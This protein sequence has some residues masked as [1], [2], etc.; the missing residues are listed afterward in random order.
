MRRQRAPRHHR[1]A[2][3]GRCGKRATAVMDEHLE[4]VAGRALIVTRPPKNRDIKD[5]LAPY[6][7]GGRPR[8]R[9]AG[10][11]QRAKRLSV[12]A[13]ACQ[14]PFGAVVPHVHLHDLAA[15]HHEAID[16]AVAF[17]RRSVGPFAVERAGVVDDGLSLARR[18]IGALH[19]LLHPLVALGVERR[20][21]ARMGELAA[22]REGELEVVRD[23]ARR[24][25]RVRHH[26]GDQEFLDD[27][28]GQSSFIG[29]CNGGA[30]AGMLGLLGSG[31]GRRNGQATG[32]PCIFPARRSYP[33]PFD[34]VYD[35]AY[36]MGKAAGL[37]PSL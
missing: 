11:P 3:G 4:A 22:A 19:L 6:A 5:I 37:L 16:I 21:L 13:V 32:T 18:H 26:R 24:R 17:E 14:Q 34:I 12:D 36:D 2:G 7:D 10:E 35:I 15:A 25:H 23:V 31:Y 9:A 33:K 28:G 29:R 27:L 30:A 20:G 8:E 1:G